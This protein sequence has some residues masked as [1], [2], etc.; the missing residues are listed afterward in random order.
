MKTKTEIVITVD[1]NDAD[2]DTAINVISE[3]DLEKI[4]PLMKAIK[5]YDGKDGY[6]YGRGE[7][8]QDDSRLM[9][10]FPEDVFETFED[11]CPYGEYGFHTIESIYVYP[12]PE[13]ERLV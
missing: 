7:V 8:M 6:N 4:R 13:K 9:Y 3:K 11:Y 5:E 1:T 10:D 12:V 2:Y